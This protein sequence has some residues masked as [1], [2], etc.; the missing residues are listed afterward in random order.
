MKR[1][2]DSVPN[3]H[4]SVAYDRAKRQ[5]IVGVRPPPMVEGVKLVVRP[6]PS[7]VTRT[8]RDLW[9]KMIVATVT[10]LNLIPKDQPI[11]HQHLGVLLKTWLQDVR[12]S[13]SVTIFI[14]S[15][16]TRAAYYDLW[17][18]GRPILTS[19]KKLA[20]L[21]K[22]TWKQMTSPLH[23]PLP[24]T[25]DRMFSHAIDLIIS[26]P[27]IGATC[28]SLILRSLLDPKIKAM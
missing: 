3:L 25:F 16:A 19:N 20:E 22:I 18:I 14:V 15:E 21:V 7:L 2:R 17:Q 8:P 9:N 13:G 12:A 26:D 23:Y 11:L 1:S 27:D 28:G 4:I 6:S 24:K 10:T 5:V